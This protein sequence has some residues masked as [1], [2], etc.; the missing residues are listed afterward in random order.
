MHRAN[1]RVQALNIPVRAITTQPSETFIQI[2]KVNSEGKPM[3]TVNALR[4]AITL[5]TFTSHVVVSWRKENNAVN[6]YEAH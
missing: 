6:K 3:S 2:V 4:L 1:V 5:K